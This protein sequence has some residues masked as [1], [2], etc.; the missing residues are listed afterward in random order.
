MDFSI[1]ACDWS[2]G[3]TQGF[4][5]GKSDC[6]VIGVFESQTLSGAALEI[7]TATKGLLTRII[8]AGDMDG[9][10]GSTLFLHEVSGIGASRVLLVG[11]GKQ[12]AFTQK[13]YGDALRAAWR[14]ILGTKIVQVTFTLAQAPIKER[15]SDWAVRAAILA[16]RELTY[17]F[18]QMKSKPDTTARA[19]KRIVFTVDP[20]DEKLAKLAAKQGAALA[21]GMDLTRDL[22][23]LPGNVCTPTYLAN[24]AKKLAKDWKLKVEVLGQ[25]QMEALKMGSLLSVAKGSVEPP[26]FIVLQY[27]GGPAKAAPVVLVGKGIT[28]DTGGI[29]LKPGDAM[30][31]MKYDMCGAGS[32][33]GTLR[34]VAEMGLK[35][36]V[37]GIIPTC[38]NMPSGTATKPG[39]VVTSMSG[40]TIEILNTDAEGRLILADALTYAERFKP[41]AVIDIATLTGACII[42]L[43]HHNTGLFARDDALAGELLDAA[44]EAADPAWRMPLDDEY[45]D[46][47][48]SNFA[49]VANIGGRPAGSVTAACFLARFTEAYPWAHLD[50]AGTAWKSGAAKGAT[51]RPVPLLSQFLIDRAAQ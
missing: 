18:T 27:H 40:T 5:T 11:L 34:A 7:D 10:N 35:L 15:T 4:L 46:L 30:D 29:S 23:N 12:D 49:D 47:L 19:L 3:S 48:K 41:A 8:K 51:G 38:E 31:E 42:A 36:N 28:F 33:L 9:K 50:I 22:G 32:V 25:K 17:R 16:L 1:K 2:K 6:I 37:V 26:H 43:G 13:A 24:T 39:D 45:Q 20:V 14:A 44:K 21:N